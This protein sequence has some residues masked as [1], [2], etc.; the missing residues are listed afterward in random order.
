MADS[1]EP[2]DEFLYD[3]FISYRHV[4]RDRKWAEWL[5]DALE[6]YRVPKALQDR[7]YPARLRKIFRDEDEAPASADLSDE[8]KK[9]LKA[10]RFLIVVCSPYTPRSQWVE[11]EIAIFHE[12]GRAD[13]VLALLTEGEPNDSFP[14]ALLG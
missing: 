3:A 13:R 9:A 11:R 2:D 4:E 6:R 12:L 8:I 7:G 5:I 1:V 14:A 10:S